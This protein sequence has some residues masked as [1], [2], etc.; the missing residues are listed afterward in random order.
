[1]DKLMEILDV[2][3]ALVVGIPCL[4]AAS[5]FCCVAFTVPG[6]AAIVTGCTLFSLW[7]ERGGAND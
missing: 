7:L 5:Y 6:F 4:V 2:A 1:M 3:G